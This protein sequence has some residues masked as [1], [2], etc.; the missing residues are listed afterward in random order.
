[1]KNFIVLAIFALITLTGKSQITLEQQI[2]D[3]AC[4]CLSA[5]DTAII[6]S[7]SNALKMECLQKAMTQNHESIIKNM[8]TEKRKEEDEQ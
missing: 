5:I 1:M 6:K 2:A 4:V 3:S 7:K 8:D